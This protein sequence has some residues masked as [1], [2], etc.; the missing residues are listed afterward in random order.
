MTLCDGVRSSSR[1]IHRERPARSTARR[2]CVCDIISTLRRNVSKPVTAKIRLL[3]PE[4]ARPTLDFVR[5]LINAGANAITIHGRIVG[6]ESHTNARWGTLVDVVRELKSTESVP[7]II[8]GDLYMREDIREMKHR[9][10]CDGVMLARPA[11]YNISLFNRGDEEGKRDDT[12]KNNSNKERI[13]F[14]TSWLL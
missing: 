3:D 2:R 12:R 13:F 9:T 5:A 11:L 10:G 14:P 4:D 6:D 1:G 7:I 8:N